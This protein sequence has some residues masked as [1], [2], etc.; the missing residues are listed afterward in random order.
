MKFS[1]GDR[2][3]CFGTTRHSDYILLI[4]GTHTDPDGYYFFN[5]TT[6]HKG[7]ARA[8]NVDFCSSKIFNANDFLK[9]ML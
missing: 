8:D 4:T 7:S 9:D 6:Q 5:E 2:I 3:V 1:R